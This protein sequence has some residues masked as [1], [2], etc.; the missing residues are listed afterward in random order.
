MTIT[1]YHTPKCGTSR[2]VL[3][4]LAEAGYR[5][6]VVEYLKDGWT[7]PQLT[8]LFKAGGLSARAALR[9]KPSEAVGLEEASEEQLLDA[10]VAHPVLVNRPF[11]VTPKGIALC[12]PA[13]KV[14]DLL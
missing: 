2:K 11:V 5:P 9:D 12:R 4:L 10:M 1:V 13:E 14:L 7:K 3:A 8:A 6:V